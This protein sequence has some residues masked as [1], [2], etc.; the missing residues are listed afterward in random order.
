[1]TG[2]SRDAHAASHVRPGGE[3]S[4]ARE[5]RSASASATINA[6]LEELPD[7]RNGPY[8]DLRK[9][10]TGRARPHARPREG[11][12]TATRS[13]VRREG[14]A[15]IALVGA[16]E[17][18]QVVAAPG[19]VGDPDQD[20]RLRLHD[21][22]PGAGADPDRRRARPARRDPRP[23]RGC[24]RGPGRRASAARRAPQRRR[25]RLLPGGRPRRSTS[26]ASS[27]G[28][29][30][31]AGIEKPALV[32]A[33]KADEARRATSSDSRPG[34]A[35]RGRPGLGARRREPRRGS[36]SAIWALTGLI[37]VHLRHAG[38][39]DDEP[40]ALQPGA[41]VV[42]VA[43][44]IHHEL[45]CELRGRV[46]SGARRRGS[47]VSGSAA[48][49]SCG[50]ATPSRFSRVEGVGSP[51]WPG[52]GRPPD[53]DRRRRRRRGADPGESRSALRGSADASEAVPGRR[54]GREVETARLRRRTGG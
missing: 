11:R 13:Q 30:A 16:A 50:T 35:A 23:D 39:S 14:A 15:Q 29:V 6:L 48:T 31:A 53:S 1:M 4:S 32:A 54:S 18:G 21:A 9:W 51:G 19:A 34:G 47:T 24:A 27:G 49:T 45:A 36:R 33:T 41:T 44:S 12:R 52:R 40:L 3:A 37:R 42:D 7:Y 22:A 38:E 26:C 8:A 28:E 17:R 10:L 46:A 2:R 43:D 5:G 25:D 20:G